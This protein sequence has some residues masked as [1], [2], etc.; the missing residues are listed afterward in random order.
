MQHTA[1]ET[2]SGRKTRWAGVK[3][4]DGWFLADHDSLSLFL[5]HSTAVLMQ[6]QEGVFDRWRR[7]RG[8]KRRPTALDTKHPYIDRW[9][10]RLL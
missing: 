6:N 5:S 4:K 10:C 1:G 7:G 8:R 2:S 9:C 3:T